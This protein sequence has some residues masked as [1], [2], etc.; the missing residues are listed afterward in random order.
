[1]DIKNKV[2]VITGGAIGIGYEIADRFLQKGA[3]VVVLLD[4]NEK[5]GDAAAKKLASKHGNNRAVFYK[6]DVTTDLEAVWMNIVKKYPSI[7]ILVNNAGFLNDKLAKKTID[8]NVTALIEWS[9]KYWEHSRTDKSGKGGT[10][11]NL[12]S[13]YGYRVDQFLPVYQ[14]SKFAVMGFTKSLGH[15]YNFKRS[16]VRVMA[17]CPGFTHTNLV[18][19]VHTFDEVI[20]KDVKAFLKEQL[21]QNVDSVGNAVVDVVEKAASGTAWLIEGGKP[22]KEV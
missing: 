12:A 5:N 14:A 17:I 1:M 21:W 2:A 6:C 13:I 11:I 4:I 16:G 8:I 15:A 22:I 10:I 20:K 9:L 19:E 18:E 3:C 7:D